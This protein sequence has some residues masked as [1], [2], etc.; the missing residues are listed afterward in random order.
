MIGG[1]AYILFAVSGHVWGPQ[2]HLKW[3]IAYHAETDIAEH[4]RC[5]GIRRVHFRADGT[6]YFQMSAEEDLPEA[7]REVSIRVRVG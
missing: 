3:M 7:A 2:C 4:L 1:E 6:P 5:D